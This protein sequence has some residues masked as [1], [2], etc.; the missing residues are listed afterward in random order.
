MVSARVVARVR[1][2]F[3]DPEVAALVTGWLDEWADAWGVPTDR[4]EAAVV[5][6]AAGDPDRLLALLALA[7]TDWRD[8]LMATGF[9][10]EGWEQRMAAAFEAT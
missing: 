6:S 5:L 1:R 3:P 4:V 2:D 10:D 8:V 7:H 9:A